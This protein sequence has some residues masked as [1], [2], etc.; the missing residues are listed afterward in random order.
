MTQFIYKHTPGYKNILKAV[1]LF[2]T[3][4]IFN[5]KVNAQNCAIW[6]D[7]DTRPG[8]LNAQ[9]CAP[10]DYKVTIRRTVSHVSLPANDLVLGYI[11]GDGTTD[12]WDVAAMIA[13][14]TMTATNNGDGTTTYQITNQV[15]HVYPVSNDCVYQ[16]Q[17]YIRSKT[18]GYTCLN[19]EIYN[20]TVW[21]RD[22]QG[23]G[24]LVF[25][26][27]ITNE[28]VFLVCEKQE[29]NITFTDNTI[30]ACNRDPREEILDYYTN[31]R[32]RV[33]QFV[34]GVGA[35]NIPE[36]TVGSTP[37]SDP[38]GVATPYSET[39][40]TISGFILNQNI[41]ETTQNIHIPPNVT[42]AGQRFFIE[43]RHWNYCNPFPGDYDLITAEILVVPAPPDPKDATLTFCFSGQYS[44][45][46]NYTVTV[47]HE[48]ALGAMVPGEYEWYA[49]N[50]G[51]VGPLVRTKVY[52]GSGTGNQFDPTS[53]ADVPAAFDSYRVKPNVPG[54]YVFWVRYRF[55]DKTPGTSYTCESKFAKITWVIR[56]DISGAPGTPG[57]KKEGCPDE[58]LTLSYPGAPNT[59]TYGGATR[60]VWEYSINNGSTWILGDPGNVL[61]L[62]ELTPTDATGQNATIKLKSYPVAPA[63]NT[64]QIRVHREWVNGTQF[65]VSGTCRYTYTG[66]TCDKCP[67]AS[68]TFNLTVN[69]QPMANL[70]NGGEIC[71]D[72]TID[73]TLNGVYAK[74]NTSGQYQV[75]VTLTNGETN[76]YTFTSVPYTTTI[77]ANPANGTVTDYKITQLKDL[78]TGCTSTA[79]P[80]ITGTAKVLK[81]SVLSAPTWVNKPTDDLC[82]NTSY[83]WQTSPTPNPIT[84]VGQSGA[85][86][87]TVNT[88]NYW[89]WDGTYFGTN[90]P[91]SK[92]TETTTLADGIKRTIGVVFRYSSAANRSGKADKFCSSPM[93]SQEHTI[94][95]V[96]KTSVTG[97][98]TVCNDVASV[99]ITLNATGI[100]NSN[101][102]IVW[103][104]R[105]GGTPVGSQTLLT[106]AGTTGGS[107]SANINI[108]LITFDP[109]ATTRPGTYTFEVLTVTQD[110]GLCTGQP[111]GSA[112][113]I[114]RQT[115]T[116]TLSGSQ[117]ICE[118]TDATINPPD[119]VLSGNAG[120]TY[121]VTYTTD[122]LGAGSQTVTV[123]AGASLS[124]PA[125]MIKEGTD[126]TNV[127]ITSVT[128]TVGTLTCTGTPSG[129]HQINTAANLDA[130]G[131]KSTC[132]PSIT[133]TA[134]AGAGANWVKVN[135]A[136]PISFSNVTD[137]SAVVT[138]TAVGVYEVEWNNPAG[139]GCSD[140]IKLT[141]EALPNPSKIEPTS[142]VVCGLKKELTGTTTDPGGMEPWERGEWVLVSGPGTVVSPAMP[143]T[144]PVTEFEVSVP[145][146]YKFG[147]TVSS[148]CGSAAQATIDITFKPVPIT[149][150]VADISLCPTDNS[151]ITFTNANG[152]TGV[153]YKW[154]FNGT[155]TTGNPAVITAP[156]N[157]T[158][159]NQI[160]PVSVVGSLDGCD[161]I[162]MVFNVTVK[163]K[164]ALSPISDKVLCPQ[165]S[166]VLSL[167]PALNKPVTYT[168]AGDP[169]AHPNSGMSDGT[170]TVN[171]S[172]YLKYLEAGLTSGVT[173]ETGDLKV[174]ATVDGCTSDPET[175]TVKVN[176][177][178]DITLTNPN[179]EYCSNESLTQSDLTTFSTGV[180]NATMTWT[181]TGQNTG[182]SGTDRPAILVPGSVS[183]EE[184]TTSVFTT[185]DNNGATN[186][187][188][189][190]TV[191]ST[192]EGCVATESFTVTLKPRP[193]IKSIPSQ[194]LC[195]ANA[196]GT[197][198]N[199]IVPVPEYAYVPSYA[200]T[201]SGDNFNHTIGASS[202]T[203]IEIP[204]NT[205]GSDMAMVVRVV[206]KLNGCD[207]NP[208][209][210][211]L[212]AHS[213]PLISAINNQALC[214]TTSEVFDAVTL[215]SSN[216]P[217]AQISQIQWTFTG[218]DVGKTGSGL[219]D[220]PSFPPRTNDSPDDWVATVQVVATT[221]YGCVNTTPATFTYTIYPSPKINPVTTP[222]PF[223]PGESVG[224]INFSSQ[225]TKPGVTVTYNWNTSVDVGLPTT[226][227]TGNIPAF[228]AGKNKN[229]TSSNKVA[230]VEVTAV[231]SD[232]SPVSG[233]FCSSVNT[234]YIPYTLKPAPKM[235]VIQDLRECPEITVPGIQIKTDNLPNTPS[236]D[237]KWILDNAGI[238]GGNSTTPLNLTG[239][240]NIPS[241]TTKENAGPGN[242]TGQFEASAKVNGCQGDTVKFKVIIKPTPDVTVPADQIYCTSELTATSTFSSSFTGISYEWTPSGDRIG[243]PYQYETNNIGSAVPGF[244]TVNATLTTLTATYTVKSLKDGCY[245][246]PKTFTM[247]VAPVPQ[248]TPYANMTA[249][250]GDPINPAAF[251]VQTD[252]PGGNTYTYDY[253]WRVET[254]YFNE[255][256]SLPL[257][258]SPVFNNFPTNGTGN[259]PAFV[260]D[261]TRRS[262]YFPPNTMWGG[263]QKNVTISVLPQLSFQVNP[264]KVC[265]NNSAAQLVRVQINPIPNTKI[266]PPT[267]NCVGGS[268][269]RILYDVNP[270]TVGS[271]YSWSYE[272]LPTPVP[273]HPSIPSPDNSAFQVY[274]YPTPAL[275]WKGYI[276]V[277]E[278]NNFGCTAPP[279]K[280][281]VAVVPKPIVDAGPNITI[282]AGDQ[283]QLNATLVQ[284]DPG[285]TLDWYPYRFIVKDG[286][287]LTPTVTGTTNFFVYLTAE[288]GGCRSD[289][290]TVFVSVNPTPNAPALTGPTYCSSVANKLVQATGIGKNT[291]GVTDN[292][293]RWY[294]IDGADIPINTANNQSS[295]NVAD[296]TTHP[297]ALP[298]VLN[299]T[300]P[301][302][303][304]DVRYGV[305]VFNDKNCVSDTTFTSLKIRKTPAAPASDVMEYCHNGLTMFDLDA[306]K[307][308]NW[309][310]DSTTNMVFYGN[311]YRATGTVGDTKYFIAEV[312]ANACL[313]YFATKTLRVHPDPVTSMDLSDDKGCADFLIKAKNT[314]NE[315]NVTY[316]LNWGDLTADDPAPFNTEVP[317]TYINDMPTA[318]QRVLTL[319]ALSTVNKDRYGNFCSGSLSR[320]I[321]VYPKLKVDFSANSFEVC[322]QSEVT[323][324]SRIPTQFTSFAQN[325]QSYA[326]DFDEDNVADA[327]V[328]HPSWVFQ[329]RVAAPNKYSQSDVVN[330]KL[331]ATAV[332]NSGTP[333]QYFCSADVTKP[334]TVRPAPKAEYTLY[335]SDKTSPA[336]AF[337]C[338]PESLWF[339][340]LQWTPGS[341][342][343]TGVNTA[344]TQ[345]L[346]EVDGVPNRGADTL[347][348]FNNET[349]FAEF[350]TLTLK[351]TNEFGCQDTSLKTIKVMPVLTVDFTADTA[352]CAPFGA[353]IRNIS[354]GSQVFRWYWDMPTKPADGL[355]VSSNPSDPNYGVATVD[356]LNFVFANPSPSAKKVYHVWLQAENGIGAEKCYKN[357]DTLITVYPIPNATFIHNVTGYICP[358]D[359]VLFTNTSQSNLL[360]TKYNW[361]FGDT[362]EKDV[363]DTNPFYYK[364]SNTSG[365]RMNNHL[366][367]L[368]SSNTFGWHVCENSSSTY[369][370]VG[371]EV[372]AE[373]DGPPDGCSPVDARFANQS[374]GANQYLWN[375][376]PGYPTQTGPLP[377]NRYVN[378]SNSNPQYL[379]VLLTASNQWCRDTVTHPFTLYPEPHVDF[380]ISVNQ[381][382]QP[383]EV[384]FTNK[385]YLNPATGMMYV[386]EYGDVSADTTYAVSTLTKHIYSNTQ[387]SNTLVHPELIAENVW[388]CT[389]STSTG[390][391]V[392]PFV[393]ADFVTV[394]DTIGCAPLEVKFTN[395]SR[396][397]GDGNVIWNFG[398]NVLSSQI[399]PIHTFDNQSMS[400]TAV[401]QVELK[402]WS[403][404]CTD[405]VTKE[406]VVYGKPVADFVATP[407]FQ[408]YPDAP[409]T[410]TNQI[411]AADKNN[412]RYSWT[413]AEQGSGTPSVISSLP[414]PS[415]VHINA[416]GKYEITQNV[417]TW[418]DECPNSK[419]MVVEIDAPV[420][421]AR[422][423]SVPPACMPYEVQFKNNSRNGKVYNWSFGDGSTSSL[424]NPVHTYQDAG[425]Y[426]V[427]LTVTGDAAFPSVTTQQVVV[428]P[429]PRAAF[430]VKPDFLW[431][432][433]TLRAFNYTTAQ[434]SLGQPYDIWYR[435]DW[436]DGSAIDTT[437]NPDHIYRKAG[438]YDIT[439]TTGT[440]TDPQCVT[441]L[442]IPG[443]VELENAGDVIFPNTFKPKTD[444][445]P[446]DQIS[447]RGY[448]NWLFYPPVLS[449]TRSYHLTIYNRWGQLIFET[450]DPTRGW[451]GYFKG[452]L[453]QEGVYVYKI[454][455][456]FETGQ[457]FS[458]MGDVLLLR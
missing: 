405:S 243:L 147:W 398:D 263:S 332:Y 83:L 203:A 196:P 13:A 170:A 190:V 210:V 446:S 422:F 366:V 27:D 96:P 155:T 339:D 325:I 23:M 282:C 142:T 90:N 432:G 439:L 286:G 343:G 93:L 416:W 140:R 392:F 308:V 408:F 295:I 293:I 178:P 7:N 409:I 309:Y 436:G 60:F 429:V 30:L 154:T 296:D 349:F 16:S 298:A 144:S 356:P 288:D 231:S 199:S 380:D 68:T 348:Q 168:W 393:R 345:Y 208:T 335:A 172:P 327:T 43:A 137:P 136:D 195:G 333:Q 209:D 197:Y 277:Q 152:L 187:V 287:T 88:Q 163:P 38:L 301:L 412:L 406:I 450:K 254:G 18:G 279:A 230:T 383:L 241:F 98:Q 167:N 156:A 418:N 369:I 35:S 249:C 238:S 165:E 34:Y 131:D 364:Y 276:T 323:P 19:K 127:T 63:T 202:V 423:D 114:I 300:G 64:I 54:E 314:A 44:I 396:G 67:G 194:E 265:S 176:P 112:T 387:A 330:V 164:P 376:G 124:V 454:E 266:S 139:A 85:S 105:K 447:D 143:S 71:P 117:N 153:T 388:G 433:Q 3:I 438:S 104:L 56:N 285:S 40:R 260:G 31:Q 119:F 411:P 444:G 70:T 340:N 181:Y 171:V 421:V 281:Y 33:V 45:A 180:A 371:P 336:P 352:G 456:V 374:T 445:E 448:Q 284:G 101:W 399:N 245:S 73:L 297:N 414:D 184:Y 110:R 25:K 22:S 191:K 80:K 319:N 455:G 318:I 151:T 358:P 248:L 410:I 317:H 66:S 312:G 403:G 338:S 425:T 219:G 351:A 55:D 360:T 100:K 126:V 158:T 274:E 292:Y 37:V 121:T 173:A 270:S 133:M 201:T 397:Y 146:V 246:D 440:Y 224:G 417:S 435:W 378:P 283:V 334:V 95:P 218:D 451:N 74:R 113:I 177:R 431:V 326:W 385:S 82:S 185:A 236:G 441:T 458:K 8:T 381:G 350:K 419:T 389:A 41:N 322:D 457:T 214:S 6:E 453:C 192:A 162:P 217:A 452:Q 84:L 239:T 159:T 355:P 255:M 242:L 175:F 235:S 149:T 407:S 47:E 272:E 342:P 227:Q 222:A 46:P 21:S 87:E 106:I 253:I 161:A 437:M 449:P 361:S 50:G 125:S 20:V 134:T 72:E 150:Q 321:T 99:N 1:F 250:A 76:Q 116:A 386:Y 368:T 10:R 132:G 303:E 109:V 48:A 234:L 382:C 258:T 420:P 62:L 130:G 262:D 404:T 365:S 122:K 36:V 264:A 32:D 363:Y 135:P 257:A 413:L 424:E 384:I 12:E 434:N 359:S 186:R 174:T 225:I 42:T 2:F 108:P 49:D 78:T 58:V 346:W 427:T 271:T 11:W 115:P 107:G 391:T 15:S 51:S 205:T 102:Q 299:Y 367:T 17:S 160:Y 244:N 216:I 213:T 329:S 259:L 275:P 221:Q 251:S 320:T 310:T 166:F 307:S 128:Q 118:K 5:P 304:A 52:T 206:P 373:F 26:D 353:G 179:Q 14:G 79:S 341:P 228:T 237:I 261:T 379:K 24:Q 337:L 94:L 89:T 344:A 313:S 316:F 394:G 141:F 375:F 289:A 354:R 29:V 362:Y 232:K 183:P 91:Q 247:M 59:E 240:G 212:T 220:I 182:L 145:G 198:F 204:V 129:T 294:R 75:E 9:Y 28:Q 123:A 291:D 233:Q 426:T 442:T 331:T 268:K 306:G 229:Y 207:G 315:A 252:N 69:P 61:N 65:P 430:E 347:Y 305:Y 4:I 328:P 278:T 428:H 39:E 311:P 81:R 401:Y 370:S 377:S 302:D 157:N 97:S 193:I 395:G 92:T 103:Q 443:A 211:T 226:P 86:N 390:I 53:S 372:I 138:A 280:Q 57:G 189:T 111:S 269:P 290:D 324:A 148:N 215:S 273:G 402:V 120:G 169:G 267:D 188:G 200:F 223:C 415:P 400:N 256:Q 357:K 77:T